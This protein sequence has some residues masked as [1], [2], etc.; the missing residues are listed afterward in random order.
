[1]M[2]VALCG[3]A[4]WEN[5][6]IREWVEHYRSIGFDHIY[7]YDNNEVEGERF[8]E[9]IGDYIDDGFVT[10]IDYRGRKICQL[11]AYNECYTRFGHLYDW[12]AFFDID[13]FLQLD[14]EFGGKVK[15]F[16]AQKIFTPYIA[17]KVCWKCMTD[18]GLLSPNGNY[19]V[20]K[21]TEALDKDSWFNTFAKCIVRTGRKIEYTRSVHYPHGVA[22]HICDALGRPERARH[23]VQGAA[24]WEKAVLLHFR[25]KTI[26]E[27]ITNK[28]QRLYP[29]HDDT[30]SRNALTLDYFW[31][32][33]K[34]TPEKE[35]YAAQLMEQYKNIKRKKTMDILYVLGDGSVWN[36]NEIKYSLRSIDKNGINVGRIFIATDVLPDFIDPTKVVH[37]PV[38]DNPS[39][40][41]HVNIMNKI[42]HVMRRTNIGDDFLLSSDDHF[43]IKPTDFADYPLYY[44]EEALKPKRK[45]EYWM[46]IADTRMFLKMHGL[47]DYATNPHCNT[48]FNRPLY[49]ANIK[50]MDDT[51]VRKYGGEVNHLMGNLLIASGVQPVLVRDVKIRRFGDISEAIAK[52]GDS[53]FFSISDR[54]LECGMKEY[55]QEL[56]P[57]KSRWEK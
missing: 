51:K 57:D 49:M 37:V 53:H 2:K 38:K 9:V 56:F 29:D 43:Y 11:A 41:K 4:K 16:L 23:R 3:I 44:K 40:P 17:V 13:E 5:L 55:L 15:P 28:M 1:M 7:L 32:H 24:V 10:V 14:A 18:S 46:S 12:M 39:K 54:A 30:Y 22:R 33:N 45:Q 19:S 8:D 48:H 50:M 52:I 34:R 35:A 42:E 6:Y 47:T 36:N 26:E 31:E 27:Y 21:F 20:W 25:F